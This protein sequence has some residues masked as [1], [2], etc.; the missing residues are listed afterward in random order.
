MNIKICVNYY[1]IQ[2]Q[3]QMDHS[4]VFIGTRTVPH[5]RNWWEEGKKRRIAYIQL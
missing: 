4:F 2:N 3:G 1:F 5:V